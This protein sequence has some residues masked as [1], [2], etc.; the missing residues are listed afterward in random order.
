MGRE[1]PAE[2]LQTADWRGSHAVAEDRGS[3]SRPLQIVYPRSRFYLQ[4]IR[5][6]SFERQRMVT[7]AAAESDIN[8][9]DGSGVLVVAFEGM[10]PER[11][12]VPDA[13]RVCTVELP[14]QFSVIVPVSVAV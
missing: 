10:S 4:P 8:T 7:R 2:A 1:L 13:V 14:L 3:V 5:R 6:L 11:E 9:V 12:M